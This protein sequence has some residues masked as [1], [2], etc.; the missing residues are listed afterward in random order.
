[1]FCSPLQRGTYC[2]SARRLGN[3]AARRTAGL[4]SPVVAEEDD[5]RHQ[6]NGSEADTDD[7]SLYVDPALPGTLLHGVLVRYRE[8]KLK[9][10]SRN[11]EL[12]ILDNKAT[13]YHSALLYTIIAI[14]THNCGGDMRKK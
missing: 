2:T 8:T 7:D 1:M 12:E 6:K 11:Y 13:H 3:L 5:Q 9:N 10:I 4:L 14:P